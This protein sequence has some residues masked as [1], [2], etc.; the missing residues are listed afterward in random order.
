MKLANPEQYKTLEEFIAAYEARNLDIEARH[1]R[2]ETPREIAS[3]YGLR[4]TTVKVIIRKMGHGFR[5]ARRLSEREKA[6]RDRVRGAT[7]ALVKAGKIA[8]MPCDVCGS[9]ESECH[10]ERYDTSNPSKWVR[11][12][13]RLHHAE[14]HRELGWGMGTKTS[15]PSLRNKKA[16]P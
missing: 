14:R 4:H 1:L 10:H 16:K 15:G 8:K 11:W 6:R 3:V 7:L 13:C 9:D 5:H 12:L 2:G